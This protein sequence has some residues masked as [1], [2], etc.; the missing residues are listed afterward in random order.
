MTPSNTPI[1]NNNIKISF[2]LDEVLFVSPS[3]HKTEPALPFPLNKIFKERLRFG[4][5]NLINEL[6]NR[7]YE[8][9]VYT[10]S[11]R[12][13]RYIKFLFR[14]YGVKFDEIVNAQ[15]HLKE[16]QGNKKE[17]LPQKIPSKYRIS[18]HVDDETVVAT[19]G[20]AY[21]FDVFQLEAQDDNW[22][23]KILERM[24]QIENKIKKQNDFLSQ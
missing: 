1:I 21:G 2:D 8:V 12:T 7:G 18:L 17:I 20:K 6:K 24:L 13:E 10:S 19:Y 16:V 14:C 15:R 22:E 9:W 3:T 4:A 23:E 11:Y 5:P